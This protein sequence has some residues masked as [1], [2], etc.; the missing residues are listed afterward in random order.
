MR[1]ARAPAGGDLPVFALDVVD[2]GRRGPGQQSRHH[3]TDTF[4][5]ARGR[6]GQDVFRAFVAQV[7]GAGLAEENA[8]RVRQGRREK[9]IRGSQAGRAG[10]RGKA[11]RKG[12]GEGKGERGGE[13]GGGGGEKK[14]KKK[15]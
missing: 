1:E 13:G 6:E 5:R 10:R 11:E 9:G 7:L 15:K 14:K 8:G 12:G 4:A 2:D 3:Q